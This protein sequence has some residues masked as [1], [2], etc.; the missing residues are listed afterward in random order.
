METASRPVPAAARSAARRTAARRAGASDRRN[1]A[2]CA[3]PS[4]HDASYAG[5]DT[6]VATVIAR[7][8]RQ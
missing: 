1:G 6:P 2:Y 8:G 5:A 3:R 4:R 7:I